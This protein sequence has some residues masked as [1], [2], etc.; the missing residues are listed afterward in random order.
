MEVFIFALYRRW[1]RWERAHTASTQP[2][3]LA[4]M[5]TES[6]A[7]G[8]RWY[9]CMRVKYSTMHVISVVA[10]SN[11]LCPGACLLGSAKRREH[12]ESGAQ[13]LL[14]NP[15]KGTKMQLRAPHPQKS[16]Q[17]HGERFGD[18]RGDLRGCRIHAQYIPMPNISRCSDVVNAQGE[19]VYRRRTG[20]EKA[21][22]TCEED[23]KCH[24]AL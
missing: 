14:E 13:G 11:A 9:A 16:L 23:F 19:D 6:T 8:Q 21:T 4:R 18:V 5:S 15:R 24:F 12:L 22:R 1:W 3:A 17:I 2:K 10:P 20:S 7:P